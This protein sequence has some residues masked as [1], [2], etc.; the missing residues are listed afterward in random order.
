[1]LRAKLQRDLLESVTNQLIDNAQGYISEDF[2]R[3]FSRNLISFV[4]M[5]LKINPKTKIIWA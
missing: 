3:N 5:L 1:M 4:P 2:A